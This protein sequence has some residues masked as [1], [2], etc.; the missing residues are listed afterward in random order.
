[1]NSHRAQ[2]VVF[3]LCL[4]PLAGLRADKPPPTRKPGLA[5][6]D[7]SV[8][9]NVT[10][11]DAGQDVA[12]LLQGKFSPREFRLIDR[13]RLAAILAEHN[14]KPRDLAANPAVLRGKKLDG[15]DYLVLGSLAKSDDLLV[16]ARL[17]DV[18]K[19][20][21]VQ[22]AEVK[23]VY[24]V[25]LQLRLAELARTLLMTDEQK[26]RYLATRKDPV[27]RFLVHDATPGRRL[28]ARA[29][30]AKSLA[31]AGVIDLHGRFPSEDGTKID[32][33]VIKGRRA[34]PKGRSRATV[35]LLHGIHGSKA[36]FLPLARRLANEGF[37]VVLPD[38]RAHGASGGKYTTYG[39]WERADCKAVMDA[40][41][42]RKAVSPWIY[43][44]GA[45]LGASTALQYAAIDPQRCRGVLALAPFKDARSV[46][47]LLLRGLPQSEL[48]QALARAGKRANFVPADASALKAV[49]VTA[50][51]ILLV[52]AQGDLAV[53]YEHCAAIY[54]AA[55]EPKKLISRG[56]VPPHSTP[57]AREKWLLGQIRDLDQVARNYEE[58]RKEGRGSPPPTRPATAPEPP[59]APR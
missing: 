55:M 11:A 29:G 53:P 7:F 35:L 28:L 17:V 1:M 49:K 43:A 38:L 46:A 5:V 44:V 20:Q 48:D 31:A 3:L 2:L 52:A 32:V 14:L 47:G 34:K 19:G 22:A 16:S 23:T 42:S 15:V 10:F 26:R 33:W 36:T 24:T 18:S 6:A 37:D 27:L 25:G 51:P 13:K 45:S 50:C 59:T 9:E 54:E 30:S 57:A 39:A 21:V 56:L 12:D 41:I 4:F 8:A 40:L 58:L